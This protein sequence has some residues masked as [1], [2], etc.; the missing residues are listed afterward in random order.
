[1]LTIACKAS[2][3]Q[4]Q[5]KHFWTNFVLH[6]LMG[7][8]KFANGR[9]MTPVLSNTSLQRQDLLARTCGSLKRALT[10]QESTLGLRWSCLPDSLGYKHRVTPI[11]IPTLRLIYR[12][13]ASQYDPLGY[14]LPYTTRAK[15]LVQDLWKTKQG[16]DDPITPSELVDRWLKWEQELA[17]LSS[18]RLPRCYVHAWADQSGVYRELHFFCDASER[19]Y[20]TVVYLRVHDSQNHVHVAF[21]MAR[22]R[23]SPKRQL[24][25]PRLELSAALLGAQLATTLKSELTLSLAR[26]ILWSDSTTVLTWLKS[27]SCHYK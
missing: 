14:I 24:S 26:T 13:L 20:G 11:Q 18:I 22:S 4:P 17:D 2:L 12:T 27:E 15:V 21:V 16:W 10:P 25:M 7:D 19:A 8:L 1:M 9:V 5:P 3:L 23:V 6:C